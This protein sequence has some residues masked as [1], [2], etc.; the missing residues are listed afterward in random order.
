[1]KILCNLCLHFARRYGQDGKK[2]WKENH[3]T[4]VTKIPK[5]IRRKYGMNK[6]IMN[7]YKI[8]F[9]FLFSNIFLLNE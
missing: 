4:K 9:L 8:S 3:A 2:P 7:L 1:M 6:T 5:T